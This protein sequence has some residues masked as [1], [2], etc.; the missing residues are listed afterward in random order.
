MERKAMKL[1]EHDDECSYGGISAG[2][3]TIGTLGELFYSS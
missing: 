3:G 2:I 1:E